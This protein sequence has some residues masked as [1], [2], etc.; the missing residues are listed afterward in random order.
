MGNKSEHS[1]HKKV[2]GKKQKEY[3]KILKKC[4]GLVTHACDKYG[5]H[6][7]THYNWMKDYEGFADEVKAIQE[8]MVD[9]AESKL[10]ENIKKGDNTSILFYLK[11][12]AKKRGYVEKQE[13]EHSGNVGFDISKLQKYLKE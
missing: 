9:F 10:Y 1:I 6:S 8:G 5:I 2:M 3:L 12:K 13:I 7:Q 11:C 4:A